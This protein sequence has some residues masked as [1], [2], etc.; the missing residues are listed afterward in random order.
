[1]LAQG[2]V[3][4]CLA[5]AFFLALAP[6]D[7]IRVDE[8]SI[9]AASAPSL[10]ADKTAAQGLQKLTG[11]EDMVLTDAQGIAFLAQRDVPPGL[12]DTSFKRIS[13]GFLSAR[14]IIDQ[15]ERYHVS[16][17]LLW[18]GRL[19]Q[20]PEVSTWIEGH[21]SRHQTLD[22]GRVLWFSVR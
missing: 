11:R 8:K 21:F 18:T 5:L 2:M 20:L 6:W 19:S 9:S 3:G 12:A 22:N 13:T 15:S 17:A 7:G 4:A 10:A 14:E 16:A 1:M